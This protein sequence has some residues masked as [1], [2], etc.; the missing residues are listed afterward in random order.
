MK[1]SIKSIF[2][3]VLVVACG[4]MAWRTWWVEANLPGVPRFVVGCCVEYEVL[5][6]QP[7]LGEVGHVELR[8]VPGAFR[9][10]YTVADTSRRRLQVMESSIVREATWKEYSDAEYAIRMKVKKNLP[11]LQAIKEPKRSNGSVS[12]EE[13][14][15]IEGLIIDTD[16]KPRRLIA[17]RTEQPTVFISGH[18]MRDAWLYSWV[19][20]D[21]G[22]DIA[23]PF[24]QDEVLGEVEI[25]WEGDQT[26]FGVTPFRMQFRGEIPVHVE[27]CQISGSKVEAIYRDYED[28]KKELES[29]PADTSMI[30]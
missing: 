17:L 9:W 13:K 1:F 12:M 8:G 24:E 15:R 5:D 19:D 25:P 18:K 7:E 10:E 4:A 26:E 14:L 2:T 23:A 27:N 28:L 21:N 29:V 20:V 6:N 16:A 3:A 11:L 30:Q 22:Q